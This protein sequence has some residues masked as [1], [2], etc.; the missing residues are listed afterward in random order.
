VSHECVPNRLGSSTALPFHSEKAAYVRGR[1]CSFQ[2]ATIR[3]QEFA[4]SLVGGL[5]IIV[6][7]LAG[8]FALFKSNGPPRILLPD[9]CARYSRRQRHHTPEACC[10]LPD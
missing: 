2:D 5:Q 4:G 1:S 8:M 3:K 6:D 7:G 10:R 9:G